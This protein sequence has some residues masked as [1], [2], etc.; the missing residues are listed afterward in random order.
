VELAAESGVTLE[1]TE[2]EKIISAKIVEDAER[3]L[4]E[5]SR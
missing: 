5:L 1:I 3:E 4:P 2:P